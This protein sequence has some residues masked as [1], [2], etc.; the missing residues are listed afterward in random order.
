MNRR[1]AR[2]PIRIAGHLLEGDGIVE[3]LKTWL[4]C[5]FLSL[6]MWKYGLPTGVGDVVSGGSVLF[7]EKVSFDEITYAN[8]TH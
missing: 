6:V 5:M 7:Y 4:T 3:D 8:G 2:S 1:K